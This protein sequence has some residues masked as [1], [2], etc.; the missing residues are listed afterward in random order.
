MTKAKYYI[1]RNLR[2][3]GFSVKHK[4]LVV[5]L[6]HSLYGL[7]VEFRVSE[8]GRQKV[9]K[10]KRKNVHAYAACEYFA[11]DSHQPP[12]DKL[13]KITYN[14][15]VADYFTC[16]GKEINSAEEVTFYDGKCYL[17]N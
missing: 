7:A 10:E 16:D 15:Y 8:K 13:K 2:T 1:Y 9:I 6:A 17:V 3:G 12:I 4:G 11:I 5:C 14:P